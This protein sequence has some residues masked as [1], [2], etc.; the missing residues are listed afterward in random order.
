MLRVL[1]PKYHLILHREEDWVGY[2][3]NFKYVFIRQDPPYNMEYISSMHLL[4]QVR[5]HTKFINDP[6]GIRNAP[7]KIFVTNFNAAIYDIQL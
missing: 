1:S 2:S 4:E 3:D 6:R 7:E 5:G